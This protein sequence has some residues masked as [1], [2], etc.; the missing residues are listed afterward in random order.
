MKTPQQTADDLKKTI[1]ARSTA[2][3]QYNMDIETRK[4]MLNELDKLVT[5]AKEAVT[6]AE[7]EEYST[8]EHLAKTKG[9]LSDMVIKVTNETKRFESMNND[10]LETKRLINKAKFE[11]A[12]IQEKAD[13]KYEALQSRHNVWKR[14]IRK[15]C[16]RVRVILKD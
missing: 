12:G 5:E 4:E 11:L 14:N 9:K 16:D 13:T 6:K 10:V 3:N 1:S 8:Q 15:E 2:L 7:N